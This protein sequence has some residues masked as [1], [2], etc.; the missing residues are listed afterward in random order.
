MSFVI[1]LSIGILLGLVFGPSTER[2]DEAYIDGF[3][4]GRNQEETK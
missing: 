3:I 2:L 1:G 4:A